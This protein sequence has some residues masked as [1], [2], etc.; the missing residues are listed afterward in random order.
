MTSLRSMPCFDKSLRMM[1]LVLA[2]SA[3]A[4]GVAGLLVT[5]LLPAA[6]EAPKGA[7]AGKKIAVSLMGQVVTTGTIML[8]TP[9]TMDDAFAA[10]GGFNRDDPAANRR[11]APA[12]FCILMT[13]SNGVDENMHV[14]IKIDGKT[15]TIRVVDKAWKNVPL[16]N[17]DTL[18]VPVIT[19]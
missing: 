1:K 5:G 17:G 18:I 13:R 12:K 9:A 19:R 6:A 16:K 7:V 11:A 14:A 4:I 3:R 15:R 8:P 2:G 10:A